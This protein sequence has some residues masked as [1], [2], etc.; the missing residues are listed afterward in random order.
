[1]RARFVGDPN[2]NGSGPS[3]IRAYGLDFE[4]GV[5]REVPDDFPLHHSHFEVRGS[6]APPQAVN[7]FDHDGDGRPGGSL[8]GPRRRGPPKSQ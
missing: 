1:M 3:E 8:P 6:S 4:K 5:W 2:D 7:P